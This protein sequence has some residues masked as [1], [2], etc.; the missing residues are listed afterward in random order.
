MIKVGAG[1]GA[2]FPYYPASVEQVVAVK[3][4]GYLRRQAERAAT[5]A[6]VPIAIL[7]SLANELP[8]EDGWLDA[9]VAT[10]ILCTLLDRGRALAK[11]FRVI[12]GSGELRFYEHVLAQKPLPARLQHLADA[13]FWPRVLGAATLP[14]RRLRRSSGPDA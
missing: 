14:A 2:N 5:L 13:T 11:L 1:N 12:K 9:G 8:G 4:E 10:L 6:P 7:E 3:P